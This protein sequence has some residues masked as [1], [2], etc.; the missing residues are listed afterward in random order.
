MRPKGSDNTTEIFN[1]CWAELES[2][3]P[4]LSD[5]PLR[6]TLN[7]QT[8]SY[9][10]GETIS[11]TKAK[12]LLKEWIKDSVQKHNHVT[13]YTCPDNAEIAIETEVLEGDDYDYHEEYPL[14][15]S[16]AKLYIA[17]D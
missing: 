17:K 8:L 6:S 5:V 16:G 9:I 11:M 4:E 2:H 7:P 14:K 10:Q 15:T 12:K 13:L 3:R 1:I